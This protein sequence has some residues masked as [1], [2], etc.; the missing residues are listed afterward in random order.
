M[1]I[2]IIDLPIQNHDFLMFFVGLPEGMLLMGYLKL[3]YI[4][5]SNTQMLHGAGRSTLV[6]GLEHLLL[7]HSV[8]NH[9]PN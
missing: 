4:F 2:C 1:A 5:I 8:G 7:F 3:S 9:H 6:G